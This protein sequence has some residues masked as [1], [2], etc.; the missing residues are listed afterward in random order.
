[1][2]MMHTP[3]QA[4]VREQTTPS[5]SPQLPVRKLVAWAAGLAGLTA[6]I[7][8]AVSL[9]APVDDTTPAPAPA[10]I[11]SPE[12]ARLPA[13]PDV[14]SPEAAR[15]WVSPAQPESFSPEA[16]RV[17]V[18]TTPAAAA[19]A[20]AHPPNYYPHGFDYSGDEPPSATRP[21]NGRSPF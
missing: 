6:A 2:T 17:R 13:Q 9:L 18:P 16:A 15:D 7:V 8:I 3:Q 1:M 11:F 4:P 10:E 5:D 19:E 20:P 21:A 14:F 12:A